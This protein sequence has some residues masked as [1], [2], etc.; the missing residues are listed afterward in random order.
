M[1]RLAL[2]LAVLAV[3]HAGAPGC[4]RVAPGIEVLVELTGLG[5]ASTLPD[6]RPVSVERAVVR[7]ATVS[8]VPCALTPEGTLEAF[9][10]LVRPLARAHGV[11]SFASRE[12]VEL[13]LTG[14]TALAAIRPPPTDLCGLDLELGPIGGAPSLELE[15]HDASG[16]A[17]EARST[18]SMLVRTR[19]PAASIDRAGSWTVHA[20]LLPAGLFTGLDTVDLD[21]ERLGFEQLVSIALDAEASI[22]PTP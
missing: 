12:P 21:A 2:A 15:A 14:G 3:V 7:V 16:V 8:L 22:E 6:G 1:R 18:A 10:A 13:D 5:G 4:A 9:V 20:T 11:S 17:I 19:W